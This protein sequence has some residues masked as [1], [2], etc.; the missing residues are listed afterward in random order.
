MAI[1]V[2]TNNVPRD[3]IY[4]HELSEKEAKEF[5]YIDSEDMLSHQ[6]FRFKGQVY[7]ASD[8]MRATDIADLKGWDGYASDSYFSGT[9]IKFVDNFE[10]VIVGTYFS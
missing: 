3:L 10:R 8:F 6:F 1:T 4:G 5:D 7:D 2:K 9:V